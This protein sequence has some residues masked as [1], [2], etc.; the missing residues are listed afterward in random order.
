MDVLVL[1]YNDAE[2]TAEFI[3]Y[4]REYRS[5]GRIAVVDNNST[6]GSFERLSELADGRVAVISSDRNGG[7]GYGNNFGIRYLAEHGESDFILLANPDTIV[8]ESTLLRLEKFLSEN[9]DYAM[10]APFMCNAEG[11]RM[12]NTA[13]SVASMRRVILSICTLTTK[14]SGGYFY[15]GLTEKKEGIMEVDALSGSLFM[16][17]KRLM[18]EHGMY[19]ENIF[20]YCEELVLA[21]KF[22]DAGKKAALLLDQEFIHNHSVSISKTFKSVSKREALLQASREYVLRTYYGA[23]GFSV[24]VS[25][26][27]SKLCVLEYKLIGLIKGK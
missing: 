24:F 15:R 17:N 11:R 16:M 8:K 7:Y 13:F 14:L 1:N 25:R 21:K 20:L 26:V 27:L 5:V 3:E 22:K 10:A 23:S 9:P 6:D 2:T 19:D 12:L 4:I 18:L